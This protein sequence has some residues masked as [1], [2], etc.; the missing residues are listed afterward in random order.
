MSKYLQEAFK[1]TA[2]SLKEEV[3]NP[4]VAAKSTKL[5]KNEYSHL[6]LLTEAVTVPSITR[7]ATYALPIVKKMLPKLIAGS[8]V[9]LQPIDAPKAFIRFLKYKK[10]TAKGVN[11]ADEEVPINLTGGDEGYNPYYSSDKQSVRVEITVAAGV[12]TAAFA[13]GAANADYHPLANVADITAADDWEYA[14]ED[15]DYDD[16]TTLVT[17]GAFTYATPSTLAL[18]VD[19]VVFTITFDGSTAPAVGGTGTVS[20]LADGTY[21]LTLQ[22]PFEIENTSLTS[23]YEFQVEQIQIDAETRQL[24]ASITLESLLS[25]QKMGIEGDKELVDINT[26]ALSVELDRWVVK[27]LWDAAKAS[28]VS[29]VTVDAAAP[30]ASTPNIYTDAASFYSHILRPLLE[31]RNQILK[32]SFRGRGN[33]VVVGLDVLAVLELIG[34]LP[35]MDMEEMQIGEV[36]TLDNKWKVFSDVYFPD[37]QIL[38][39]YRSRTN[40]LNAGGVFAP[41]IPVMMTPPDF[42]S[43]DFSF[44]YGMFTSAGVKVYDNTCYGRM[45]VTG[46]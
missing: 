29:T 42:N 7:I 8:L 33:F 34:K 1:L 43:S 46:L 18:T 15:A 37:T 44:N 24:I 9:S 45:K 19:G 23:G 38:H 39:G 36:G 12:A 22:V 6:K 28:P 17:A 41:F 26:A 11:V 35:G 14:L 5:L 25:G 2:K 4:V 31:Q 27:T 32:K 21:Y 10:T 16:Y 3:K 20:A 13:S 30:S 40:E